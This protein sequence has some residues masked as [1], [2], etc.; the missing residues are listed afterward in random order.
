MQTHN[1]DRHIVLLQQVHE[2]MRN[3]GE[4]FWDMFSADEA[5]KMKIFFQS[6]DPPD[7]QILECAAVADALLSAD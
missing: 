6:L 7:R 3:S 4:T 5:K 1:L 2:L